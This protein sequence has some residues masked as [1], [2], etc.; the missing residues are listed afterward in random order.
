M[1]QIGTFQ[2]A[3]FLES[4]WKRGSILWVISEKGFNSLRIIQEKWGS[5]LCVL[6]KKNE[7]Q[8]FAY[9]WRKMRVNSLRI[10]QKWGSILRIIQE[11]WGLFFFQ[12]NEVRFFAYYSRKM[13]FNS[14]RIIQVKKKFSS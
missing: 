5:I 4:H 12:E 11:K 2:K 1:F 9:Y 8:F 3:Q 14:L 7:G 10:I 13:R 6:L